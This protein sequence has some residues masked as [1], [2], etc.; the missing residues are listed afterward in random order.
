MWSGCVLTAARRVRLDSRALSLL[1]RAHEGHLLRLPASFLNP[2]PNP[3]PSGARHISYLS[4]LLVR[5][6]PLLLSSPKPTRAL[7]T[8][9]Y[10]I[11][12]D[13]MNADC[14][15]CV[16]VQ[17]ERVLRRKLERHLAR[18]GLV[19]REGRAED[20]PALEELCRAANMY[21]GLDSLPAHF[22]A[23]LRQPT[24]KSLVAL[25]AVSGRMVRAHCTP[26]PH[27]SPRCAPLSPT[28]RLSA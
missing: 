6:L 24:F 8:D 22:A 4:F 1:S 19:V 14:M 12:G 11:S 13:G 18:A 28:I 27:M 16:S 7:N 20:V 17:A 2:N 10:V 5:P 9:T 26:T 3:D 25:D 21:A 23:L 15:V